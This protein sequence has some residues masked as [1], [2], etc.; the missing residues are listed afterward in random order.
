M[1]LYHGTNIDF[2]HIDIN[3]S[4]PNKD[5]GRGFY[6]SADYEQAKN[7]AD[8]K[9][10]QMET[11]MPLVQEYSISEI[12][13]KSL[14]CMTFD[15]YTEEWAKFILLN[16]NNPS[17]VP[18]HDYDIVIGPIADDRVGVQLWKYE[19]QL[20]D[21]PT[22]IKRLKYMKGITFQYFFGTERAIK[23]LKRI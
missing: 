13:M 12:E 8:I 14:K 15:D 16:R 4:K 10:E 23:L 5:F 7:M 20:I 18:A 1:K 22:L 3:K 9:V 21:L 19:S 2:D 6:L 17:A 11:G